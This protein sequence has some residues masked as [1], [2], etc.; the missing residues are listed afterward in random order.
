MSTGVADGTYP[1][2]ARSCRVVALIE[3]RFGLGMVMKSLVSRL[4]VSAFGIAAGGMHLAAQGAS[5]AA[6]NTPISLDPANPHYFLYGGKTIALITSGEHYGAV[7]NPGMDYKKYLA[8][9]AADGLNYTRLF[10]GSYVEVPG[11]SFGIKRNDL[12][13]E[14][15]KFIAPWARSGT[16]GYAGGGNKFDLEQWNPEYFARLHDFLADA[17][18]RGIVVEISLFSAQYGEPQWALSPFNAANNVNNTP[19]DDWK[20]LETIEN[21]RILNYQERYTRKLVHEVADYSNVIF[22]LQN[23]PW[24]DRPKLVDEINPYLFTGRDQYPNSVEVPDALSIAW[25]GKVAAWIA[26]EEKGLGHKH[27][28]AQNYTNFRLPVS[29][30]LPRVSVVNFHYA[31]PEAVTWNY[32]LGKAIGYDETGFLSGGD[33][34]YRRQAWNFMLS[35][36]STFDSLDYSFTPG[37]ETGDDTEPNGPGGGSPAL[38]KQLGVLAEF[39]RHLPLQ[40]MRPDERVVIH[41]GSVPRALSDGNATWAI[42]LYTGALGGSADGGE[43]ALDL[44]VGAFDGIWTDVTT[45]HSLKRETFTHRGSEKRLQIPANPGG[46]A[47]L[48]RRNVE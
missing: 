19:L 9:L 7:M 8:T 1:Q 20:K 45:G 4:L 6:P 12:A 22:E 34:A 23:E 2:A 10:G 40:E 37:H 24:S 15:G 43:V 42:Y 3:S 11:K 13:P 36:G 33:A 31:Y 30:L 29:E 44:P 18:R 48:L 25:Q 32:G 28:I 16:A 46:V 26:D 21:G 17:E 27:L 39:L 5:P 41:A 38:R 47:L 14:P 35:G